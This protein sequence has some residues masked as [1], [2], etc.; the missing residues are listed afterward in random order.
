MEANSQVRGLEES[1]FRVLSS[2]AFGRINLKC[3]PDMQFWE[4]PTSSANK[5]SKVEWVPQDVVELMKKGKEAE[6][7]GNIHSFK[8][9]LHSY[10]LICK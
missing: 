5:A 9:I 3:I 10:Y 7:K 4:V 1:R 2:S 6:A 8:N